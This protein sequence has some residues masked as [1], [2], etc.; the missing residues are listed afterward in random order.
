MGC[1]IV[2]YLDGV[3]S[4]DL[5]LGRDLGQRGVQ[6]LAV[7][8]E[9]ASGL[10]GGRRGVLCEVVIGSVSGIAFALHGLVQILESE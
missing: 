4:L 7:G 10:C 3:D 6:A 9:Q 2:A 1:W 5:D 8:L